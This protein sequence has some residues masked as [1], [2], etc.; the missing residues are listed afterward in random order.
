MFLTLASKKFQSFVVA[1]NN[2]KK[3]QLYHKIQKK[4][5]VIRILLHSNDI[6]TG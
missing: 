4:Q 1:E 5:T 2:F 3:F 6:S